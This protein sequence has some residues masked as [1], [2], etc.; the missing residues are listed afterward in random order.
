VVVFWVGWC[1]LAV[2][3]AGEVD[4]Y[5]SCFSELAILLL[6]WRVLLGCREGI[7]VV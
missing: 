3:G 2:S 6:F 1:N 4:S 7:A 5:S